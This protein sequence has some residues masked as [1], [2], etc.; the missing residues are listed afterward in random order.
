MGWDI[1]CHM[2]TLFEEAK[3]PLAS[4]ESLVEG[5]LHMP[6]VSLTEAVL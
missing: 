2:G 4:P 3:L 1:L 6:P 5:E